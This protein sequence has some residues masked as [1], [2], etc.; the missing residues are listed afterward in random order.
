[1][2]IYVGSIKRYGNPMGDRMVLPESF[3]DSHEG[4]WDCM[5]IGFGPKG[6]PVKT[7]CQATPHIGAKGWWEAWETKVA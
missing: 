2:G 3:M 7:E 4:A 5:G 6:L 1:M